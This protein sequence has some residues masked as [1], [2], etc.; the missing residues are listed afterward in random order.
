MARKPSTLAVWGIAVTL[1]VE[2]C[3]GGP[4]EPSSGAAA[5]HGTLDSA[6]TLRIARAARA[7]G[8]YASAINLYREIAASSHGPA[9]TAELG[10]TLLEAGSID[11]AITAYESVPANSAGSL[12]AA[13]GLEHAYVMLNELPQAVTFADKA[14]AIAPDDPRTLIDRGIALDLSGRHSEAQTSYRAL[15]AKSP[16][17][18]AA[19][20]DLALS[21]AFTGNY[22]EAILI[23][24][25]I[26][27]SS[28]ASP[29]ERQ[30]LALIYG[31]M[32]DENEA[33]Q[34][35]LIDL[36]QSATAANLRFYDFVRTSP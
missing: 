8:D 26:A 11:E 15:L 2:G 20:V 4:A 3:A 17:N 22:Q 16:A 29:R 36:D 10:D 28:T 31:L 13:L 19:R 25:P 6:S 1:L 9:V 18:R 30:D 14:K 21:L 23:I 33:R 12:A 27:R 32:G 24:D 34:L 35:S 5:S 7:A